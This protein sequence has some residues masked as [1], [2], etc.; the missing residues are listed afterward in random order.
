[1]KQN[2]FLLI[3]TII[4]LLTIAL[5]FFDKI[6]GFVT[7][8]SKPTIDINPSILKFDR[9]DG[10]KVVNIRVDAGSGISSFFVFKSVLDEEVLDKGILCDDPICTGSISKNFV[11]DQ[12]INSGEYY[13]EFDRKCK[14]GCEN[15]NPKIRSGILEIVHV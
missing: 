11:V 3:I 4:I 5:F 2:N 13:F 7:S 14:S 10:S 15:L 1:M 6:S 8:N 12:N 9:Y